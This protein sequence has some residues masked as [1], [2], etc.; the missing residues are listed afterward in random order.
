MK[1]RTKSGSTWVSR[2][3]KISLCVWLV[4]FALAFWSVSRVD[5]AD[6]V[7]AVQYAMESMT[8]QCESYDRIRKAHPDISEA[9]LH[10]LMRGFMVEQGGTFLITENDRIIASNDP[11]LSGASLADCP[12]TQVIDKIAQQESPKCFSYGGRGYFGAM[13]QYQTFRLYVYYPQVQVYATCAMTL[14]IFTILYAVFVAVIL[15]MRRQ[16]GKKNLVIDRSLQ[17]MSAILSSLQSVYFTGFY[18]DVQEDTYRTLFAPEWLRPI[19]PESGVYSQ[20]VKNGIPKAVT[21]E[22]CPL[23]IEQLSPACIRDALRAETLSS[24]RHSYSIDYLAERGGKT[25]WCRATIILVDLDASGVPRHVLGMLQEI[26]EQK[27]KER[28]SQEKILEAAKQARTANAAKTRFLSA[29][30]HDIRTPLNAILGMAQIA[31]ENSSDPVR[32]DDCL[33]KISL[34]GR[35]LLTLVNDVLDITQIESGNLSINPTEFDVSESASDLVNILYP[36]MLQKKQ[37]CEIYLENITQEWLF[38]DKLR[39]NQIWINLISNAV[40]YT[41]D[42]GRIDITLRERE[43]AD[44]P[45]N[46]ELLFR[47]RDT[48]IGMTE[49]FQKRV[50][51][52]F[53]RAKDSRIDTVEG[54]GLG[55]AIVKQ[56]V[57]LMHGQITVESEIGV[58]TTFTVTLRLKKA[59]QHAHSDALASR[60]ILLVGEQMQPVRGFLQSMGAQA[61]TCA[62]DAVAEFVRGTYDTVIIDRSMA[63]DTCL[64]TAQALREAAGDREL[65]ILVSAFDSNDIEREARLR[66]V[67]GFLPRPLFRPA[68]RKGLQTGRY[69]RRRDANDRFASME[70]IRILVAEDNEINW[71][72]VCQMLRMHGLLAERAE[73]G[74]QCLN[75]LGEAPEGYYALILMDIQMPILNG[76]ETTKRIRALSNRGKAQ[77]PILAMTANAF[78]EDVR[79]CEKAGMNGHIAKPVD[80]NIL[81]SS[82]RTLVAGE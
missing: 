29:M 38:A 41:P 42:G 13:T 11:L 77:I 50:F 51:E 69:A 21:E 44:D 43:L 75:M 9:E 36:Q 59:M 67:D 6:A 74:K 31:E 64:D 71:E 32:V 76:F 60:R 54:S 5:H 70:G 52:T 26:S 33:M 68:L 63:D 14:T 22:Y 40:K 61:E 17:E 49:A 16:L 80:W 3:I 65:T 55:M 37:H 18:V 48:G 53:A 82:I 19:C 20:L 10:S 78:A 57:D 15:A 45:E 23:L 72:I 62:G 79:S 34:A 12:I 7:R 30:S 39:L 8:E 35:H 47:V 1:R 56:L 24:V 27:E 46:I 73:N 2:V 4:L 81:F 66:G 25:V 28:I 58:G